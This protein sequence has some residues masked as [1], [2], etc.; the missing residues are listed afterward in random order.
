M[1]PADPASRAGVTPKASGDPSSRTFGKTNM[2]PET[3]RYV[4]FSAILVS[5]VFILWMLWGIVVYF[6][7]PEWSQKGQAGDLF[8]GINA[9]FA[10]LAFAGVIFTVFLQ[11]REL[12]LQRQEL[13]QT[14][15]EL[16]RAA[17]AQESTQAGINE[18]VKLLALSTYL[19]AALS[20]RGQLPYG[21]IG[22]L[23]ETKKVYRIEEQLVEML[24]Q[25]GI[26]VKK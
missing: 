15:E 6:T 17:E 20:T 4:W 12:A 21:S 3:K 2:N 24:Q 13:E 5:L 11:T 18:Q 10:G 26:D 22:Y 7:L 16:R 8:G 25:H 9:L 23:D 19:S 14:R 1:P